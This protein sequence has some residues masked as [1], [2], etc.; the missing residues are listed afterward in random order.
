[1]AAWQSLLLSLHCTR[2]GQ[3]FRGGP[4]FLLILRLPLLLPL[5]HTIPCS[6]IHMCAAYPYFPIMGAMA[7][8]LEAFP[9]PTTSAQPQ[10]LPHIESRIAA[11]IDEHLACR[12]DIM[13]KQKQELCWWEQ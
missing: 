3:A 7:E 13:L 6:P 2:F 8:A 4:S 9:T 5:H 11:D 12:K 1:M 10:L